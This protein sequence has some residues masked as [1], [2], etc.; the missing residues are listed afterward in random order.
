M[1]M[2][3]RDNSIEEIKRLEPPSRTLWANR[4]TAAPESADAQG[5]PCSH[6]H[7]ELALEQDVLRQFEGTVQTGERQTLRLV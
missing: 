6:G 1:A 4:E 5:A 3:Q 2:P 7:P